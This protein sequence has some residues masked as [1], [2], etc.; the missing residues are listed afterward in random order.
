MVT[1]TPI[2]SPTAKDHDIITNSCRCAIISPRPHWLFLHNTPARGATV[3]QIQCE[4]ITVSMEGNGV[5]VPHHALGIH[6]GYL[7]L[8]VVVNNVAPQCDEPAAGKHH[9]CWGGSL[10]HKVAKLQPVRWPSRRQ[11]NPPCVVQAEPMA[12]LVVAMLACIDEEPTPIR[13]YGRPVVCSVP[14]RSLSMGALHCPLQS[15]GRK[16]GNLRERPSLLRPAT[17]YPNVIP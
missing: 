10:A 8:L 12:G 9:Q 6:L 15:F 1:T 3:L 11:L 14:P 16:D 2:Q 5:M 13:R 7:E 4:D 17:R